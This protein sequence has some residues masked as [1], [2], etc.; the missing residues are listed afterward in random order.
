MTSHRIQELFR[1]LERNKSLVLRTFANVQPEGWETA[2]YAKPGSWTLRELLA[3]FV[4]SERM[5]LKLSKD[6]AGGGRG[7][8]TGFDYDAFNRKEQEAF[9]LHKPEELLKLFCEAREATIEWMSGL[10]EGALDRK[11]N[12]PTLGEVTLEDLLSAI[13]GHILLHIRE[14]P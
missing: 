5:L 1:K 4:S 2:V 6:V 7:A 9:R 13:H 11:G 3:H 14:L 12:H 8:P 10:M